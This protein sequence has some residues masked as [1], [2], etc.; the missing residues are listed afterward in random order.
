M[1]AKKLFTLLSALA[2]GSLLLCANPVMAQG[3]GS[4][5]Q[6]KTQSKTQTGTLSRTRTRTSE[7]SGTINRY[8]GTKSDQTKQQAQ[9]K[10]GKQ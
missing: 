6:T 4:R 1:K 10:S 2:L 8:E 5:L 7:P 9:T 3:S